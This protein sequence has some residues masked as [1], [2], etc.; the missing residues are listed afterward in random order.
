MDGGD[1][2]VFLAV[3]EEAERLSDDAPAPWGDVRPLISE[4]WVAEY[5]RKLSQDVPDSARRMETIDYAPF[6]PR[7]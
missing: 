7:N 4:A 3:V 1:M 6:E 2:T 5:G